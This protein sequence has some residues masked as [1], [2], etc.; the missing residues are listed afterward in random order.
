MTS[1]VEPDAGNHNQSD[2]K[3]GTEPVVFLALV[4]EDL[5]SANAQGQQREAHIVE[6]DPPAQS[7]CPDPIRRSSTSV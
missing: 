6:L 3:V 2:N 1:A 5:Q 4:E 7:A